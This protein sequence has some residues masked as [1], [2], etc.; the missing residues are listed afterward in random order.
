MGVVVRAAWRQAR[1][2]PDGQMAGAALVWLIT[3]LLLGTPVMAS[4]AVEALVEHRLDQ[5]SGLTRDLR[6][7]AQLPGDQYDP[8]G[9]GRECS[10]GVLLR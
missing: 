10:L 5:V 2:I 1:A 4:A 3:V 9:S 6:A 7:V 8:D